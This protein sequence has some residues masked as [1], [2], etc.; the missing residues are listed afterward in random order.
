MNEV[1]V[2]RPERRDERGNKRRESCRFCMNAGRVV[3]SD[4][5]NLNLVCLKK[6]WR[7]NEVVILGEDSLAKNCDGFVARPVKSKIKH[8]RSHRELLDA[9]NKKL[10]DFSKPEKYVYSPKRSV[11]DVYY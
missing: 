9:P 4:R 6:S 5:I 7:R 8:Y 10:S 11:D 1:E 2:V 3:S